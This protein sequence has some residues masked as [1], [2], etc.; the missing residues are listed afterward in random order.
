MGDGD[1]VLDYLVYR[2]DLHWLSGDG[3]S[4]RATEGGGDQEESLDLHFAEIDGWPE[5][6]SWVREQRTGAVYVVYFDFPSSRG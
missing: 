1:Y 5:E 2:D 4:E 6:D 3:C